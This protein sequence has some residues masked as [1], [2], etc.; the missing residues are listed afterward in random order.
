MAWAT[1]DVPDSGGLLGSA[2]WKVLTGWMENSKI[3]SKLVG[4]LSIQV[5]RLKLQPKDN[6]EKWFNSAFTLIIEL[7]SAKK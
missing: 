1:I 7:A 4:S 5:T 3:V 6:R 2:V